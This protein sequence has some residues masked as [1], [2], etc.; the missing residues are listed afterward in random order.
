MA[1]SIRDLVE[2]SEPSWRNGGLHGPQSKVRFDLV[3]YGVSG[4]QAGDYSVDQKKQKKTRAPIMAIVRE[5]SRWDDTWR[6]TMNGQ[7]L[8]DNKQQLYDHWTDTTQPDDEV[9]PGFTI[10]QGLQSGSVISLAAYNVTGPWS[11]TPWTVEV[12]YDDGSVE[13]S[14]IGGSNSGDGGD[15]YTY[16]PNGSYSVPQ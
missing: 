8:V 13:F 15:D 3:G 10:N 6:I 11:Y 5:S 1:D 9:S 14:T 4:T 16:F 12:H 2:A 7:V